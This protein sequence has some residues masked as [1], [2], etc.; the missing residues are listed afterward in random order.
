MD[1]LPK[2][3]K[4]P[5]AEMTQE[6]QAQ[7]G[8]EMMIGFMLLCPGKLIILGGTGFALG[9]FFGL[10]MALM[11]YDVPVG[12]ATPGTAMRDLPLKEQMKLQFLD[13]GRR[14]Y[15]SAKNFGYIGMIYLGVECVIESFRAKNDIYNGLLAGCVTGGG[16]AIKSGPQ[17][18][19]I[20]CAGFAVFSGAIDLYL[21][22]ELG[23]PPANDYDE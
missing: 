2:G 23:R 6:E 7:E 18:A 3:P 11:A 13:M 10:F 4:K 9:G 5:Y 8:A 1:I 21:R 16:L 14:L 22:L 15:L 17:A 12:G 19:A 20:G